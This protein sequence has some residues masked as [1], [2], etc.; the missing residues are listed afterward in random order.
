MECGELPETAAATRGFLEVAC[1][2][3]AARLVVFSTFNDFLS[4]EGDV[5]ANTNTRT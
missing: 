3:R 5:D 4:G 2:L 1:R